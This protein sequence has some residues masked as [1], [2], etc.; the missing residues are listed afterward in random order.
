MVEE[1][2]ILVEWIWD[3]NKNINLIKKPGGCWAF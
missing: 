3:T 2:V 1:K